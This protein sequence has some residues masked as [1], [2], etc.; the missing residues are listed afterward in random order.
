MK[1]YILESEMLVPASVRDTFEFFQD[2]GNLAR[3]TPPEVGFRILTPGKIEM[4][5]GLEIDYEIRLAGI[6]VSWRSVITE[7]EP[8]FF[9]V[10]EQVRGPYRFWR[11]HH[12][13]RPNADGTVIGDR[14]EYA[15][16]FGWFGQIAH[17]IAVRHQLQQIFDYRRRVLTDVMRTVTKV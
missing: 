13:F 15:M 10:D 8:P 9:F 2:P 6:P 4:R 16:P 17:W 14:V 12:S 11:H 3:V 5:K 1:I 7:F